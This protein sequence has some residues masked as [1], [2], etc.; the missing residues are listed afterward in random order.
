MWVLLHW[1]SPLSEKWC[2]QTFVNHWGIW[3][4]KQGILP[5]NNFQAHK[6][7]VHGDHGKRNFFQVTKVLTAQRDKG[8]VYLQSFLASHQQQISW[9][10]VFLIPHV[11]NLSLAPK[12]QAIWESPGMWKTVPQCIPFVGITISKNIYCNE[13]WLWEHWNECCPDLK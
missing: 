11:D 6:V 4:H 8:V 10:K 9:P 2:V 3:F 13:R 5:H 7:C 12:M 1:C